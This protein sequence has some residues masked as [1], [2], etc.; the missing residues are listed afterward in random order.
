M[1]FKRNA[2]LLSLGADIFVAFLIFFYAM[3]STLQPLDVVFSALKYFAL[4]LLAT[5]CGLSTLIRY[6]MLY[7]VANDVESYYNDMPDIRERTKLLERLKQVPFANGV[8]TG[9]HFVVVAIAMTC[10]FSFKFHSPAEVCTIM[11]LELLSGAFFSSLFAYSN[12]NRICSKHARQI[13]KDGVEK[14][15]TIK[16]K[17]FGQ[18]LLWQ[19]SL[20]IIIPFLLITAITVTIT[21]IGFLPLDN[22]AFRPPHQ[23]QVRRLII[24]TTCNVILLITLILLFFLRF[25]QNSLCHNILPQTDGIPGFTVHLNFL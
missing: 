25:L 16:K 3:I 22:P 19:I 14:S 21:I 12:M 7:H 18:N 6:I 1:T 4:L 17:I 15:Y 5:Q 11:L 13:V 10:V 23:L 9:S 2:L 20:Y 8:L 24:T